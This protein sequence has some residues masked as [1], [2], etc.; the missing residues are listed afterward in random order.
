MKQTIFKKMLFLFVLFQSFSIFAKEKQFVFA[1]PS[2]NNKDWYAKNLDSL[3]SQA[4]ENYRIIYINDA[5]SDNT[6]I[7]VENY[8]KERNIEYSAVNFA[9]SQTI[10][11][12]T[13]KFIDLINQNKK[14]FILINNE[15]RSGQ[16]CNL[17]RAVYSCRDDEVIAIVDGDDWLAH[18][19]V[20]S[21]LNTVYKQQN[22]WLTHGTLK[23]YPSGNVSW[24]EPVL[25]SI[26]TRNLFRQ[27]KCPTHLRTFYAW[28]F[29]KIRL[30]DLL[31]NGS[32]FPVTGDMA[33][34][35]PMCEMAGERHAFIS[36]V[37]YIY[38]V[39]NPINDNKVNAQLQRDLDYY[40]RNKDRYQ[41]LSENQI[42][43][44]QD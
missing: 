20:L 4:Y 12:T 39:Q 32:F 7:L 23:E 43:Q 15:T 30:E 29:K 31:Y 21:E 28:L 14:F 41:T 2:Y 11:E 6:G 35:F 5:S 3:L 22:I 36:D 37:N 9:E 38:N 25:Q 8:L 13:K 44:L 40:I 33:C 18:N 27:Y 1:V 26:I 34:M 16:L 17:Y 10:E 19:D 24:S 42:P